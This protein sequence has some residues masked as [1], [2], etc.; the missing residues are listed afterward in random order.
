M[1]VFNTLNETDLAV[2]ASKRLK[3]AGK[4]LLTLQSFIPNALNDLAQEVANSPKKRH[5]LMTDQSVVTASITSSTYNYYA[6]LSTPIDTYGVM[7]DK[8]RLGTVFYIYPSYIFDSA[9]TPVDYTEITLAGAGTSAI[10]GVYIANG[11]INGKPFFNLTG[12][13]GGPS[14]ELAY[15]VA[16]GINDEDEWCITSSDGSFR[17]TSAEDVETPWEVETWTVSTGTSPGPTIT[18][19][20]TGSTITLLGQSAIYP[21]GLAVRFTTQDTLPLG[22]AV[23]TTYYII[24]VGDGS[25]RVA[26]S[27]ADALAGTFIVLGSQG[28]DVSTVAPYQKE[29]AQWLSSPTQG[30]C[31]PSIPIDYAYIWLE[32]N[33][34][35][36]TKTAGSF[37]FDVPYQP[38]LSNLPSQ[39]Q[40]DLVDCLVNIA[41]TAGFR[42][43]NDVG[44]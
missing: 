20:H 22:L 21:T 33:R 26:A 19:S 29:V 13:T 17:Y 14:P 10:N 32:K 16:W 6:D 44:V 34:L 8:I 18:V 43:V 25:F 35:A 3:M 37:A 11:Y 28:V 24:A 5:L 7:L 23:S 36:T 1:A 30:L 38:T 40:N 42:P 27:L 39:L 4:S 2:L 9:D 15:S 12:H 41:L 31:T